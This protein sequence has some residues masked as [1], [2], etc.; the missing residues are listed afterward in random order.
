MLKL[1]HSPGACSLVP[2]IALEE[3]GAEF[4]AV[5]IVLAEGDHLKAEYLAINPHARVPALGTDQGTITENIAI[6]NYIADRFGAAGS[7]PRG[8]A[9]VAAKCNELLSWFASS[10][11][12][13]FAQVWR[14][15]RFT[16]DESAHQLLID[17][18][19]ENL[20]EHFAEIEGLAGQGWL[21]GDRFSAADSY[22]L[23][24]FRWGRRLG[25]GM[26]DYPRWAALNR[27]LL[28]QP[29][30]Q[31]VVEREELGIEMFQPAT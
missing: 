16:R 28:D 20:A 29:S 25:M 9:L 13:S 5:R 24:F 21:A 12:I 19:R 17:G 15:S 14:A 3:A 1:F 7:V 22:A 23:I 8:D 4:E 2:H 6:L 27:R 10:V 26:E 31:R 18:G 11:H 30:V